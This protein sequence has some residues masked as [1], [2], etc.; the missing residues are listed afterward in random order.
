M[1]LSLLL[2]NV[3]DNDD[4]DDDDDDNDDNDDDDDDDGDDD[5]LMLMFTSYL[6]NNLKMTTKTSKIN[7]LLTTALIFRSFQVTVISFQ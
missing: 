3:Y 7:E 4:D 1:L 2:G 5:V 6:V